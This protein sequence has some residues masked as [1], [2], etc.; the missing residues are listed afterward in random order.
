MDP[1]YSPP[2]LDNKL[3]WDDIKTVDE[4]NLN[5]YLDNLQKK[6][7]RVRPNKRKRLDS[8]DIFDKISK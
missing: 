3:V 8:V 1:P 4:N 6:K 7:D 2:T 5:I